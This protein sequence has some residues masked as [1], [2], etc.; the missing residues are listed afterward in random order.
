MTNP[1]NLLDGDHLAA[2]GTLPELFRLVAKERAAASAVIDGGR[3]ISYAELDAASDLLAARLSQAGVRPGDLVGVLLERSAT[4]VVGILAVM[5]AGAAYVPLDPLH[6]RDRLSYLLENAGIATVI[7]P[8]AL[9][10]ACGVV[11]VRVV[12]PTGDDGGGSLPEPT[13]AGD[14]PAYVIYTSGSTGRP[15]GC[16]VSH[17]NV[18]ALLRAALPLFDVS[19]SDR[20]ALFHSFS[21]DVSVWELWATLAT[22]ATAVTV[23]TAAAQ[24]PNDLVRLLGD[25]GVTVLGQ[26][27]SVFRSV[28]LAYE[29]AGRPPLTLRYLVF[30]GEPVDLD[31]VRNFLRDFPGTPPTAVNMYGPTETTVYATHRILTPA[32]LTGPVRSPI[33]HGLPHLRLEIRDAQLRPVPDGEVGELVVA[34]EGV[35]L[36]YLGLPQ[37]TAERFVELNGPDGPARYYRTGDLARRLRDGSFEYLG[38]NDQQIKLR[39]YRIELGEIEAVVRTHG[40]VRD[41]AVT[42]VSTP[43]G[44][45]FLVACV[46]LAEHAPPKPIAALREHTMAVLPRYMVPDRYQFLAEL[47]LTGSGKLDRAALAAA[48]ARPV[49]RQP[50]TASPASASRAAAGH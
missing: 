47:P 26:V 36:G 44:A 16:V 28:A 31:V 34:G 8:A 18:L 49:A 45:Q 41:V 9:A 48:T 11:D 29:E 19:T 4:V 27:P 37:L 1:S 42:V 20:W 50:E 39:G 7:A 23:P 10:E 6:P 13:L 12:E 30:A 17:R 40:F 21:F 3:A 25:E 22:G 35:A 43:A 33:G 46:V 2:A 24:S 14:D 32:D 15:K 38:R 5:K